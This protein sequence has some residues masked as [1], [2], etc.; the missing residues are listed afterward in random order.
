M[1]SGPKFSVHPVF[2]IIIIIIINTA[3]YETRPFS[4]L[5]TSKNMSWYTF[6]PYF[7][8]F[9]HNAPLQRALQKGRII[10]DNNNNA[11]QVITRCS[12]I[13]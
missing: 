2:I 13:K 8:N 11:I 1:Q 3:F 12:T 7:N 10:Q 6:S 9:I 4:N 5:E